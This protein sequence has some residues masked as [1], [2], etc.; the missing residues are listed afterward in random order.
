MMLV[1]RIV[2]VLKVPGAIENGKNIKT[3]L[4]K[5]SKRLRHFNNLDSWNHNQLTAGL[6]FATCPKRESNASFPE[7]SQFARMETKVIM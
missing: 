7:F 3:F 4:Q 5:L 2:G 6:S 1:L